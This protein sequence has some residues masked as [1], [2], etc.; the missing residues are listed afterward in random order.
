MYEATKVLRDEREVILRVLKATEAAANA[1]ESVVD[2]PAQFLSDVVEFLL[3]LRG[4]SASRE[5][6]KVC[7]SPNSKRKV[8]LEWRTGRRDAGGVSVWLGTHRQNGEA[9]IA[10]AGGTAVLEQSEPMQH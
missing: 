5:N 2:A 8:C 7:C 4:P 10:S 6:K 1:I 9:A 3:L